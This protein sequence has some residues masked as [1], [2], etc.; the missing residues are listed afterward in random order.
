MVVGW[1]EEWRAKGEVVV[2]SAQPDGGVMCQLRLSRAG[3]LREPLGHNNDKTDG[4]LGNGAAA[5]A[6]AVEIQG[7]P[8]D[9][10]GR[11]SSR[12]RHR[13]CGHA[14]LHSCATA[15]DGRLLAGHEPYPVT[16]AHGVVGQ[17]LPASGRDAET[18]DQ[19]AS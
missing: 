19:Q 10:G 16:S 17:P 2:Q 14:P 7:E 13:K 12:S 6:T 3:G 8:G 5:R 4:E 15:R 9:E 1:A 11:M 18:S